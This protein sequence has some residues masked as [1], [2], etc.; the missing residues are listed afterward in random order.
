MRPLHRGDLRR[1]RSCPL[2]RAAGAAMDNAATRVSIQLGEVR[3][4]LP[5]RPTLV[6]RALLRLDR[7]SALSRSDDD[8]HNDVTSLTAATG[9]NILLNAVHRIASRQPA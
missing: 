8:E 1:T 2:P 6:H 4:G 3:V 7:F 5:G 9:L